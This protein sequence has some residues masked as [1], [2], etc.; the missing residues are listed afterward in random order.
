VTHDDARR[1]IS[2][3]MDGERLAGRTLSAL[4]RHLSSCASCRAFESGAWRLRESARF[5][6]AE[7]V[8][9]LVGPIMASVRAD[10]SSRRRRVGAGVGRR[11][12]GGRP[13][14]RSL[15]PIAAAVLVGVVAGSLVVGGPWPG[16]RR[17]TLASA[18]DVS[19][20][21]AAAASQLRA[22]QATFSITQTDPARVPH[23]R[24]LS[25]SVDF[26]APERFRLDVSDRT[27]G[28]GARFPADD[29]ELVVNGS[30]AFQMAPS[31]CPLAVCPPRERVVRNRIPFSS[32]TPAPTDLILPVSTL[33]GTRETTVAGRGVVMGRPA[34]E[35]RLSFERARPLFPF[36]TLG[37]SWRAFFPQDRVDLWLDARSWFPLRATV[38]PA[39]DPARHEWAMRF[40]LPDEP[41]DEPILRVEALS[42]RGTPAPA[43]AFRIPHARAATDEGAHEVSI[44]DV[45]A[46]VP[47][48][49]APSDV[50]GLRLYRAVVPESG[51][52]RAVLTY[53]SGLSWLKLDETHASDGEDFFGPIGSHARAISVPDVGT[54]YYQPDSQRH[55]RRLAVH[56]ADADVYLET[57][58]PRNRLLEAATAL[59]I[60]SAPVPSSWLTTSSPAGATRRAT[61]EGAAAAMP[62]AVLLP[63][64]PP[65]GFSAASADVVRVGR[66]R[67]INVYFQRDDPAAD[68]ATVRL[69]EELAD[70]LPPASA[71]RQFS[72]DVRGLDGRWTPGRH[73]L[74]WIEGGVYVSLDAAT[75]G[76]EQLMRVAESLAP[77]T[78]PSSAPSTPDPSPAAKA[79]PPPNGSPRP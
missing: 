19:A 54:A 1:A 72:V 8:P 39:S 3:R 41:T 50:A 78:S 51:R 46:H 59:E 33:V 18:A 2:E 76:L 47:G 16:D 61:V 35:V 58:L 21:V 53:A 70:R 7:P 60:T 6:L 4:D 31:A 30:D 67:S 15:A 40:G 77:A 64:H 26:V 5:G 56:T 20:G 63:A 57:N 68:G 11:A 49:V 36:L 23:R 42:I 79:T 37:G 38:Y 12:L 43:S 71:A 10:A 17:S 13:W 48:A 75:L 24:D 45:V 74:E 44:G 32:A 34:I 66:A 22:Y 14:T 55:G 9:D 69:H 29:L 65:G 52:R 27:P 28:A 73:Q 62:F 25:M